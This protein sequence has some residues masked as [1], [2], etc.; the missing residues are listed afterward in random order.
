[1]VEQVRIDA[2]D[3]LDAAFD[4]AMS[5]PGAVDLSAAVTPADT[6]GTTTPPSICGGTFPEC[7]DNTT[8]GGSAVTSGTSVDI[9]RTC[10]IDGGLD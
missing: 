2:V 6:P 10:T 9:N 1:M 4:D 8:I 5:L 7:T 3:H